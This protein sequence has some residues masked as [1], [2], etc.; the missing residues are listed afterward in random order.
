MSEIAD[1]PIETIVSKV[2]ELA[3]ALKAEGVIKLFLFGSRARGDGR[4]DSDLD[5]LVE[6]VL[7]RGAP[8]FDLFKVSHLIEDA[9]GLQVQ[10]SMRELLK[11]RISERIADDL[12]EVF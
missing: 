8:T 4:A 1:I 6:T 11:P 9:T 2:R 3:P 12:I 7:P 5:V 10:I